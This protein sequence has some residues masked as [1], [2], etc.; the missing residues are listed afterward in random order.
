MPD[1]ATRKREELKSKLQALPNEL[2]RWMELSEKNQPFEKHN[3]QLRKLALQV[4][5]LHS[6]IAEDLQNLAENGG[7]L[8]REARKLETRML[9]V[10]SLWDYFR[11]KFVLRVQEPFAGFLKA[12]DAF[13]WACYEPLQ[14]AR[15][16]AGGEDLREPPLVAMQ[17]LWSPSALP[18]DHAY[19]VARAPGGWMDTKPFVDVIESLPVPILGLPWFHLDHLPHVVL[20]AHE[21][22]HVVEHDFGLEDNV[23][24]VVR[25]TPLTAE[26]WREAWISWRKEVFA[27]WFGCYAAGPAFV[28]ALTEVL[29]SG[30]ASIVNEKKQDP[31]GGYPTTTLRV[32]FNTAALR[33]L[34]WTEAAD[35]IDAEWTATYASHQMGH[36]ERDAASIG[37]VLKESKLLPD[38]LLYNRVRPQENR[39]VEILS[40]SPNIEKL[41]DNSLQDAR[42]LIAAA[43]TLYRAVRSNELTRKHWQ[44]L[45]ERAVYARLPGLLAP[46]METTTIEEAEK[47]KGRALAAGF[48]SAL[49]DTTIS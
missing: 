4:E 48:F 9:A 49:D 3:S 12:A 5:G 43:G 28:W 22:G 17:N 13:A 8:L 29:A 30:W 10:H 26:K 21:V 27:D 42:A 7:N 46:T 16:E 33:L 39:A 40:F 20:L 19:N 23:E 36:F 45:R 34:E 14:K 44:K 6:A 38:T 35:D 2:K 15:M 47:R 1:M 18:R 25:S 11:S 24:A 41:T 31:W 32:H 37:K